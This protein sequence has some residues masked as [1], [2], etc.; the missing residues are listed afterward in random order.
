MNAATIIEH[1]GTRQSVKEWALDYGITT[2]IIVARL[3]AGQTP[4]QAIETPIIA[5][6]GQILGK[7]AAVYPRRKKAPRK[8]PTYTQ[9]GVTRTHSQWAATL[10]LSATSFTNRVELGLSPDR[11]LAPRRRQRPKLTAFGRTETVAQWA[12]ECGLSHACITARLAAGEAPEAALTRPA[13]GGG[14]MLLT[15][16]N[17]QGPAG[18]AT[19]N[20]LPKQD[21]QT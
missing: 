21:F 5:L 11:I 19:H 9:D 18:G 10:G 8:V 6:R 3:K 1:D 7:Q 20:I 4:A 12:R 2:A 13:K 16:Q 15:S 17:P 14:G